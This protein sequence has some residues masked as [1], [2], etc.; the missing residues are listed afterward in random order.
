MDYIFIDFENLSL[1]TIPDHAD[2]Q[3][4]FLFAGEKQNKVSLDIAESM[5]KLGPKAEV[6]R[7]KG[8]GKNALDFHIAYYLGKVS[9]ADP[10]GIFKIVSKDKGFDPLVEH[11]VSKGIRCSRVENL[12]AKAPDRKG[13]EEMISGFAEHVRG[14]S[15]KARPKKAVKLKAYIKNHFRT[16]EGMA[17]DVY[18]G[19]L[20]RGVDA[21]LTGKL[22]YPDSLVST[23][24]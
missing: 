12:S 2:I 11:L 8:A 24:P 17:E 20:A 9:H 10:K 5:Q 23:A 6:I 21:S 14:L 15:E 16:D 1:Q 22:S 13:L 18:Q 4:V 19:M 3:K 7:M